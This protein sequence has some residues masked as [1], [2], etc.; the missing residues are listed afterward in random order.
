MRIIMLLLAVVLVGAC[1]TGNANFYPSVG[2][3]EADVVSQWGRGGMTSYL[4]TPY[5]QWKTAWY[6]KHLGGILPGCSREVFRGNP[7]YFG[8]IAVSYEN[9]RVMAVSWY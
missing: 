4:D 2:M 3:T 7:F 8:C 5:S 9:G 1:A 6:T